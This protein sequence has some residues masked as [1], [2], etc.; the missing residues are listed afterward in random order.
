MSK[1]E[2][3]PLVINSEATLENVK[4]ELSIM[5]TIEGINRRVDFV[6]P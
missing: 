3:M 6:Q 1:G 2:T 4:G 5:N